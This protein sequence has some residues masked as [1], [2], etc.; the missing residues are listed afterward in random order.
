MDG[1]THVYDASGKPAAVFEAWGADFV[2]IQAGCAANR[3]AATSASSGDS[4]DSLA[5]Y[6]VVN[7]APVR[8]S[9]PVALSGPVTALWPARDGALAVARSLSTG[10]YEAYSIA[11]DCGR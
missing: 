7:N 9:D 4:S 2:A 8:L 3:I 1:R 5:L 6:D 11:V 10:R